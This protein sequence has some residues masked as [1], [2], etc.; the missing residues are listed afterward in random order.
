VSGGTVLN[1]F[2]RARFAIPILAALL[3]LGAAGLW[4]RPPHLHLEIETAVV[5]A[6]LAAFSYLHLRHAFL[7]LSTLVAP[8]IGLLGS[9]LLTSPGVNFPSLLLAYL[10][11][12]IV[13][14]FLAA[15]MVRQTA[16]GEAASGAARDAVI[17][18][19]PAALCALVVAIVMPAFVVSVSPVRALQAALPG[20]GAGLCA[21]IA[22]PLGALLLPYGEDFVARA[23]RLRESRQRLLAHLVAVTQPRWGWSLSGIAI[24][25]AVLG[26]FGAKGTPIHANVA[27]PAAILVAFGAT[28]AAT[29]DWRRAVAALLAFLPAISLT[30]WV[31]ARLPLHSGPDGW[32]NPA[33]ALGIA[34]IPVMLVSARAAQFAR[35][36]ENGP[37]ASARALEQDGAAIAFAALAG[38]LSLLAMGEAGIPAALGIFLGGA[39][40]L[41]FAPAFSAAVG[42][43]LPRRAEIEARYRVR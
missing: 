11:G 19:A 14:V 20:I 32:R 23:N 12:F 21:L 15:A 18:L 4:L 40:A 25:F 5:L 30:L 36:G 7:T 22:V 41:V 38:A 43:L 2:F 33:Q 42:S 29:R 31:L 13:A 39:S 9:G 34:F 1:G 27:W 8:A 28:Y 10:P 17:E 6:I 16:G 3:A 37:I 35:G 24:V 26:L